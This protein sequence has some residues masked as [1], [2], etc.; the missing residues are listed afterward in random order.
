MSH[1]STSHTPTPWH[2]HGPDF[3]A[4]YERN[5]RPQHHWVGTCDNEGGIVPLEEQEANS[6]RIVACVNACEGLGTEGLERGVVAGLLA[7]AQKLVGSIEGGPS[8]WAEAID[9]LDAAIA[10]ATGQP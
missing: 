9:A 1:S 7:A 5:G 2:T 8:D 3:H 6:R 4:A 10:R